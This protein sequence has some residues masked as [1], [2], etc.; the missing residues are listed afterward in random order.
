MELAEV[1]YY[2]SPEN[3]HVVCHVFGFLMK[4]L[5]TS[6]KIFELNQNTTFA[7]SSYKIISLPAW[8]VLVFESNNAL[9][10]RTT[11]K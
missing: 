7:Y 2:F 8:F 6:P 11:I 3:E 9:Y 1:P 4:A 5:N 10:R